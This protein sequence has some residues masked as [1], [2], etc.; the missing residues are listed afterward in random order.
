MQI[1]SSGNFIWSEVEPEFKFIQDKGISG[2]SLVTVPQS[3]IN[4]EYVLLSGG[5][6]K[7]GTALHNVF[8]FNGTW[9]HFGHLSKPRGRHNSI[10]WN[11]AVYFIGG[12]RFYTN[13]EENK[14]KM[15]IWKRKSTSNSFKTSENWP[16]LFAWRNPFT[17]IVPDSFFPDH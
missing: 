16:E 11:G 9:H 14:L 17:F 2:H 4:E 3:E 8:K 6:L 1:N 10:Y 13:S 12:I 5:L 7:N 15:E